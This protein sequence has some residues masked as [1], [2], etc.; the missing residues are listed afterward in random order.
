GTHRGR[1]RPPRKRRSTPSVRHALAHQPPAS[2]PTRWSPRPGGPLR[3]PSNL[4]VHKEFEHR[5]ASDGVCVRAALWED[6]CSMADDNKNKGTRR[7]GLPGF[8]LG[9]GGSSNGS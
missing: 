4:N 3:T 6:G 9:G 5:G 7:G 8:D 2:A 1:R